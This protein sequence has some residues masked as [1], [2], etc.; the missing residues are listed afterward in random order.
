MRTVVPSDILVQTPRCPRFDLMMPC[1]KKQTKV[2]GT[3]WGDVDRGWRPADAGFIFGLAPS[4]SRHS[5]LRWLD[6]VKAIFPRCHWPKGFIKSTRNQLP[7]AS[8][9][10]IDLPQGLSQVL[11]H[12]SL[13]PGAACSPRSPI[14]GGLQCSQRTCTA[15]Y[16]CHLPPTSD[17]QD[18]FP[19][20]DEKTRLLGAIIVRPCFCSRRRTAAA[21]LRL[22]SIPGPLRCGFR[23]PAP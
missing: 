13:L 19:S 16:C 7:R 17:S 1:A 2:M 5:T 21:P 9:I 10:R 23:S 20:S 11:P 3:K 4:C 12:T 22:G 8:C 14:V 15:R 6:V 18:S